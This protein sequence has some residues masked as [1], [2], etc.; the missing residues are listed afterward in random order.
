M[1][2]TYQEDYP[3]EI[4][5]IKIL[6]Y[7]VLN[8]EYTKII[9]NK[10]EE[11]KGEVMI[12]QLSQNLKDM[13]ENIEEDIHKPIVNHEK[14]EEIKTEKKLNKENLRET[15]EKMISFSNYIHYSDKISWRTADCPYFLRETCF[16]SSTSHHV[17][18]D[19]YILKK[20]YFFGG[21]KSRY[22][23]NDVYSYTGKWN[24]IK[25]NILTPNIPTPRILSVTE[26][27]KMKL[28]NTIYDV[29][30]IY[31]G[32]NSK[33][34]IL[35]DVY[36]MFESPEKTFWTR[37]V[38]NDLPALIGHSSCSSDEN[39]YSFGGFGLVKD[40]IKMKYFNDLIVFG[41][42]E[43][44]QVHP[45]VKYIKYPPSPRCGSSICYKDKMIYIFGGSSF[46]GIF[47]DLYIINGSV[48]QYNI[49]FNF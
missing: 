22:F 10:A 1:K 38:K 36:I 29:L 31:G 40:D 44:N 47:N 32:M 49:I 25:L 48:C 7:G 23:S 35:N 24:E 3:N 13:I 28:G 16:L 26:S 5:L 11:L 9:N 43:N 37:N 2:V 4:P 41:I 18:K 42:N 30:M 14:K 34:E 12:F 27:F 46:K 39:M 21:I 6:E 15:N 20:S 17:S 8:E 45:S 19:D 33:L